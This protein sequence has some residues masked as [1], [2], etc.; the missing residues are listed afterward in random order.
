M[1]KFIFVI[2]PRIE[3]YLRWK[4][5]VK[6]INKCDVI[7]QAIEEKEKRDRNWNN[8]KKIK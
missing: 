8:Y 5:E 2:S 4:K 1:K 7:R 3:Q 6:N